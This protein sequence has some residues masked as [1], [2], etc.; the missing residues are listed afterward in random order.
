MSPGAQAAVVSS[1]LPFTGLADCVLL[2][3]AASCAWAATGPPVAA[4]IPAVFRPLPTA[5]VHE[6]IQ[7]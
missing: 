7:H 3:F 1:V 4:D 6:G 2:A 5:K